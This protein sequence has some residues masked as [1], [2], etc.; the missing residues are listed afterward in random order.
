MTNKSWIRTLNIIAGVGLT[1]GGASAIQGCVLPGWVLFVGLL[2][3]AICKCIVG[4]LVQVQGESDEAQH[5]TPAMLE[6]VQQV[7]DAAKVV[8]KT[9]LLILFGLF[10]VIPARA[11]TNTTTNTPTM[12][13]NLLQSI[14]MTS[15][16]AG[17]SSFAQGFVDAAP[18]VSN[19][20]VSL[21]TGMLYNKS[22]THGKLGAYLA[23]TVPISQQAGIGIGGF[24]QNRQFGNG[25]VSLTLGTTVSNFLGV[26]K[27]FG[28]VFTFVSSGPDYDFAKGSDGK[29]IGVGSY[30]A[31]GFKKRI[32]LG[33]T[34]E[35]DVNVG[36]ENIS[37]IPGIGWFGGFTV[38]K[39]F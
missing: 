2:I 30:N 1:V 22:D 29:A 39:H 5:I 18:Y 3:A 33:K 24:Y 23:A 31:A 14:G 25:E 37:C 27:L 7:H 6:A 36:T 20:I 15:L 13:T 19:S 32:A 10:L 21:D 38:T 34:L 17:W 16:G 35:L 4:E 26:G 8:T 9:A 28:P 12:A 11:Q